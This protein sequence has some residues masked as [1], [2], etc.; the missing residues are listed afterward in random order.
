MSGNSGVLIV[1]PNCS[2]G[3]VTAVIRGRALAQPDT[4]FVALF[5]NDKG[6]RDAFA[7]LANVDVRIVPVSRAAAY[8]SYVLNLGLIKE[9]SFLSC[10]KMVDDTIVP[11][12]VRVNYE[13]HSS[14]THVI[15]NEIKILDVERVD[16]IVVPS[17]FSRR[18]LLGLLNVDHLSKLSVEKNLLDTKSFACDGPT[19]AAW[20]HGIT[21]LVWVGRFDKGK[22][23]RY[24][25]RVLKLLP[26]HVRG[27]VIVSWETEPARVGEFL[28]EAVACGVQ[29]R[30]ELLLN[31]PPAEL[32]SIFRQA[33]D[34]GGAYVSTSMLESFG[35]SVLEAASC[36]LQTVAFDLPALRE[37][38]AQDDLVHFVAPGSVQAMAEVIELCTGSHLH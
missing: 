30:L 17:E 9:V 23:F 18:R 16:R 14:D 8:V 22:G 19:A 13:F 33:R 37:H 32:G 38:D 10:P 29:R 12:G 1:Y 15:A 11:E 20:D 27:T 6:G 21:P 25:L 4:Q 31:V 3:G 36:G 24:F 28:G 35:Y 26:E 34:Q 5:F 7:D 2:K